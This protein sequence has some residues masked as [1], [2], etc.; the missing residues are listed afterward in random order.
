MVASGKIP[1]AIII[2]VVTAVCFYSI[3]GVK[4]NIGF[5]SFVLF[6]G[7][8]CAYGVADGRTYQLPD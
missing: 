5:L 4:S 2:L 8:K 7:G 1:D 6:P 3:L